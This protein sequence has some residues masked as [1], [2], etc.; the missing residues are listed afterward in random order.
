MITQGFTFNITDKYN[1]MA[2]QLKTAKQYKLMLTDDTSII[3][4]S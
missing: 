1:L 2:A 3:L 4:I